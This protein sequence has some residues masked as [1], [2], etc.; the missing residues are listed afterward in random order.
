MNLSFRDCFDDKHEGGSSLS[1]GNEGYIA[2]I[3][4]KK[5]IDQLY[6]HKTKLEFQMFDG[7]YHENEEFAR[8]SPSLA[9]VQ[10]MTIWT[11]MKLNI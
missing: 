1:A 11:L 4:V 8:L 6:H 7:E 2:H 9:M 10:I 3:A 5:F